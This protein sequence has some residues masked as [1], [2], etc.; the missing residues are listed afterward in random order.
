VH[1]LAQIQPGTVHRPVYLSSVEAIVWATQG[2]QYYFAPWENA[3]AP[4]VHNFVEGPICQ[5]N[6]RL[7]HPTQKP[8]WLVER[9]LRQHAHAHCTV[10]DPFCGVG[11]TLVVSK[12]MGL[13]AV[14]VEKNKTY[15]ESAHLRIMAAS[16]RSA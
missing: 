14:G 3:G 10:L 9:L 12:K 1:H 4:E 13:S 2:D 8:E 15:I 5:G 16:D 7:D 11:T 6:E